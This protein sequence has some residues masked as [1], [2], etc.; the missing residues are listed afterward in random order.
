MTFKELL[1]KHNFEYIYGC[2]SHRFY[3]NGVY[4]IKVVNITATGYLYHE[5]NE[6]VISTFNIH[7]LDINDF[8]FVY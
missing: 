4:R 1:D 2:V 8:N 5:N 6:Y 7:H 3:S